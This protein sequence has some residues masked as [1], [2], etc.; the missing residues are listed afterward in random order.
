MMESDRDKYDLLQV[1]PKDFTELTATIAM[2]HEQAVNPY[3]YLYIKTENI[4][5]FT[6][7][8]FT[9]IPKVKIILSDTRSMLLW[10]EQKVEIL[11]YI[12]F[13]SEKERIEFK[14]PIKIVLREICRVQ[15][16]MQN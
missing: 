3:F 13:L 10:K 9:E 15:Q 2:G 5:P 7:P 12:D 1:K 11:E 6:Y 14:M 16:H 8:S 4:K